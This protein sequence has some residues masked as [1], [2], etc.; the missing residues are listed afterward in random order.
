MKVSTK[1]K[2]WL[3]KNGFEYEVDSYDHPACWGK[4]CEGEHLIEEI[5]TWKKESPK[6]KWSFNECEDEYIINK[7]QQV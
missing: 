2:N 7:L 3:K 1:L 6:F 4:S 5:K